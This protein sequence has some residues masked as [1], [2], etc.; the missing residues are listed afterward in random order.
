MT[1]IAPVTLKN[2]GKWINNSSL[3]VEMDPFTLFLGGNWS[4][5]SHFLVF[6]VM[7]VTIRFTIAI[8]D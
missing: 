1:E 5:F 6:L 3:L 2:M 7:I 4:Y 8:G